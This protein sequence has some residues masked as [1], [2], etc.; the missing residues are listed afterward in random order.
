MRS[1][2]P[3]QSESYTSL[4]RLTALFGLLWDSYQPYQVPLTVTQTAYQ[5]QDGTG[6]SVQ[7]GPNLLISSFPISVSFQYD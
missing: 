1:C 7:L 2:L 3:F 5:R 6:K 4:E